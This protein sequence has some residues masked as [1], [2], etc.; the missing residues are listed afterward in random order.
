MVA[1]KMF[2]AWT[3]SPLA[4]TLAIGVVGQSREQ[5]RGKI[6]CQSMPTG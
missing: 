2:P 3:A 5:R 6:A 1:I 4:A